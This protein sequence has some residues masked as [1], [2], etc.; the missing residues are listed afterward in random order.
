M[1]PITAALSSDASVER[2]AT[3][4]VPFAGVDVSLIT[5]IEG[6]VAGDV[7]VATFWVVDDAA[8]KDGAKDS[9]ARV[10][11]VTT[12]EHVRITHVHLAVGFVEQSC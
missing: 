12:D 2:V 7:D 10:V 8:E 6:L 3:P 4:A 1:P 9:V 11:V 5:D